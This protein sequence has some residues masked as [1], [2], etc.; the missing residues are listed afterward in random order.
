M[1]YSMAVKIPNNAADSITGYG[2]ADY[3]TKFSG[4]KMVYPLYSEET[5][6]LDNFS[7]PIKY[8]V[9]DFGTEGVLPNRDLDNGDC[10]PLTAPVGFTIRYGLNVADTVRRLPQNYIS[11]DSLN[12]FL[13]VLGNDLG[14]TI[15]M[16][17]NADTKQYEFTFSSTDN[18]TV[19]ERINDLSP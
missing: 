6:L 18:K 10:W 12:N 5:Y 14:R 2:S 4:V 7:L 19:N 17:Y 15:S 9:D 16:T 8:Q 1:Q 13:T 3:P 11:K